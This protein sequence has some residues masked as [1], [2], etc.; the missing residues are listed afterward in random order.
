MIF[1]ANP[2]VIVGLEARLQLQHFAM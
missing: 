2:P 1:N